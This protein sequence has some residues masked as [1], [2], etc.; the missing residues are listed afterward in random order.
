MNL[1]E[2]NCKVAE[3]KEIHSSLGLLGITARMLP[4]FRELL[5]SIIT[6]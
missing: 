1:S 4:R 5:K 2:W 6:F 3:L